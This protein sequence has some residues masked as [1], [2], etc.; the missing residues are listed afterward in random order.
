[1]TSKDAQK[2]L[3]LYINHGIPPGSCLQA[4]LANDLS[5]TIA[6][7]D[8]ETL[9]NLDEIVQYVNYHLPMNSWGNWNKIGEWVQKFKKGSN[10]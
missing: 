5:A 2:S 8:K 3:D 4:V 9:K 6:R 1:M 10:L 7:A